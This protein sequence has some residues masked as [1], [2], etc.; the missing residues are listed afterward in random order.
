M[1]VGSQDIRKA[2][3]AKWNKYLSKY[4]NLF[5]S[6][7]ISGS[8]PPSVFVGSYNYPRVNVGPMV[9]PIH[10]DTS[11]LDHPERWLGK[12]LDELVN[13]RLKLVRGIRR[14]SILNPEGR[15]I[16]DLQEMTMSSKPTD[17]DLEF[18]KAT[19][20]SVS[21]AN[22]SPPF[23]PTGEIKSA[24]F[25]GS[26]SDRSIEKIFYD[27]DL[28]ADEAI[29]SLYNSGV[30][31]SRIQKCF[32]I[33][34]MG[35]KRKLVPTRWSITASDDIISKKLIKEIL[36]YD[37]IDAPAVF[38]FEHLGN[39][40]SVILFPHRWIFEMEEAWFSNGTLGF[41][42]D[43][44][45]ARGIDHPPSIAGAYFA[46]RLA[47]AEY[48]SKRKLQAGVLILREIR[49]EYAVPVGVWQVREGLR[50]ALRQPPKI[51]SNLDEALNKACS[52]LS[53]SKNEWIRQGNILR[54]IR[55]K[56]ISEFF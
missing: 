45:N 12:S 41:G 21:F 7:F 6:D 4:A 1:V 19:N 13:S 32:S 43:Y 51:A 27:L 16:E 54:L 3:E 55:Q 8:S 9:P 24:K 36:D 49:P 31:I 40:F 48:L 30:D 52:S 50:S 35:I 5:S 25:S 2:I 15:Y 33:G 46:G 34:M 38:H 28:K 20:P 29:F 26:S 10:G 53:I 47:V 22:E 42:S 17:S 39:Y 44:E 37:L 11:L 23:G 14:T 56:T 18:Q